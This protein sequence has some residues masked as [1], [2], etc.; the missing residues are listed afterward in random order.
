[1]NA[2]EA[3]RGARRL[4]GQ[5][6]CPH[7]P[8]GCGDAPA[9][10]TSPAR[11]PRSTERASWSSGPA[12]DRSPRECERE[13]DQ[14]DVASRCAVSRDRRA[15]LGPRPFLCT[16]TAPRSRSRIERTLQRVPHLKDS[17]GNRRNSSNAPGKSPL[18][19]RVE[20]VQ[21]RDPS[22]ST[23]FRFLC[24]TAWGFESPRS[25]ARKASYCSTLRPPYFACSEH[26]HRA[27][28]DL[29]PRV[30]PRSGSPPPS[31]QDAKPTL[32]GRVPRS[33]ALDVQTMRDRRGRAGCMPEVLRDHQPRG[34]G[35]RRE[36]RLRAPERLRR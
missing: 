26:E 25:H 10:R 27:A 3:D 33:I 12:H 31:L 34:A 30:F 35:I 32:N 4:Q 7:G 14:V 21:R 16:A 20:R 2:F 29:F 28:G 23:G 8:T 24:L 19:K 18:R 22:Q 15:A 11:M 1:M 6:W 9:S 36:R 13:R 5:P 17:M